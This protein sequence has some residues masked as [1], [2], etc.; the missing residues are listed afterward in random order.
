MK[1]FNPYFTGPISKTKMSGENQ[2][3]R[4]GFNPYFTG[5]ISKTC[6]K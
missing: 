1:S 4:V 6:G 3:I 5:P 2:D